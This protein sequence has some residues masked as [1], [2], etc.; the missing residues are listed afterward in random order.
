MDRAGFVGDD[1]AVHHGFM[2]QAFLRPLP[3]MV[4]MAP[5]DEAELN[6]C[7]RFA[8]SLDVPSALRYPRDNVPAC[9]F[10][11]VAESPALR[12]GAKREWEL[13]RSR[14]LREGTD[15]TLIVYGALVQNALLAAQ[16]L[17]SDAVSVEVIDA[18]FCKPLDAHMLDRVLRS[19]RPV[20]TIEDHSLQNGFGSAV[21]E[22]AVSHQLPTEHIT[23]LG[24]PDRLIAHASR[25][26]QLAEVG[27]DP[28]GIAKCVRDALRAAR[29]ALTSPVEA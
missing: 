7:L 14:V 16:E 28:C 5:S 1:G 23:R 18:R 6:R 10:E 20:L 11:D 27:L 2:G 22:H 26:E 29:E 3:G 17:E 15:A 8:I 24:I 25:K 13:G 21:I 12:A 4:L 19:S 9:N